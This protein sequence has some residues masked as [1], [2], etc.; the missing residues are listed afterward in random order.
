[1]KADVWIYRRMGTYIEQRRSNLRNQETSVSRLKARFGIAFPVGDSFGGP[2]LDIPA[3]A[4]RKNTH[5]NQQ[6]CASS[7]SMQL[8]TYS[9]M[10]SQKEA[11][12]HACSQRSNAIGTHASRCLFDTYAVSQGRRSQERTQSRTWH[13]MPA[14][15]DVM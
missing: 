7:E 15:S 11:V 8:D 3:V 5:S 2:P 13:L 9:Q 1:M 4:S 10:C 14:L 6:T 12:R